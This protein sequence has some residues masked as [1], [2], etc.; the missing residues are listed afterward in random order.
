MLLIG[1]TGSLATGKSTVSRLLSSPPYSLPLIDADLLA[2]RV[3]EPGTYGY[4]RILHHFGPT[5]PDLLLPPSSDESKK[6][7]EKGNGKGRPINRAVL[8]RRVFGDSEERKRDRRVLNG[9][10]HP[11]VRLV[12]VREILYYYIRGYWA[13]VLDIPLLYESG[14]DIFCGVVVMVAVS[15]P[16]VQMR[17]LRERDKALSEE[18]ARNRVASQMGVGEKVGRTQARGGG[19]GKVVWND[20]GRGELEEEVGRVMRVVEREGGRRRGWMGWLLWGNPIVVVLLAGWA[21]W[22]GWRARRKWEGERERE[23]ARL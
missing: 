6:W 22:V 13:V 21:V 23:K 14:L 17:R 18:E 5:T 8:G 19:W 15:D 10:V 11:L 4:N 20:G 3:V 2:R 16:E 9:I 7:L 12:M 1:L